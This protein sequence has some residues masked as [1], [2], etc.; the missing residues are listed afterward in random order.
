MLSLNKTKYIY[1]LFNNYLVFRCYIQQKRY[2]NIMPYKQGVL[3]SNPCT[4]T[5]ETQAHAFTHGLFY[6]PARKLAF[7]RRRK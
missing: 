2:N 3:G 6:F 5:K 1:H 7:K 4:P